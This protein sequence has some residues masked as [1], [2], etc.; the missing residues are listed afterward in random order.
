MSVLLVALALAARALAAA[1][2]G[3]FGIGYTFNVTDGAKARIVWLFVQQIA[4]GGP[5]DRAGVRPQ[6]VITAINGKQLWFTGA[7]DAVK[8]FSGIREGQTIIFDVRRGTTARKVKIVAGKVPPDIAERRRNN[9][10]L[11]KAAER[12]H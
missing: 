9:E 7:G 12:G 10:R 4:P 6:D 1:P 8:F 2:P 11:V 5:A 3:W